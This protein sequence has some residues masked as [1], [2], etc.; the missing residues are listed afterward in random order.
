[1]TTKPHI[2]VRVKR[3]SVCTFS[4]RNFSGIA[5]YNLNTIGKYNFYF[6]MPEAHLPSGKKK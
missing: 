6:K 2:G 3:K 5:V 1:M 4:S